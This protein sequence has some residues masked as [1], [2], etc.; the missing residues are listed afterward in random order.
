MLTYSSGYGLGNRSDAPLDRPAAG[1][2]CYTDIKMGQTIDITAYDSTTLLGTTTWIA[3]TSGAQAYAYP[4]DGYRSAEFRPGSRTDT[5]DLTSISTPLR[6]PAPTESSTE[7][8]SISSHLRPG[9]IER[10]LSKAARIGIV[11][12]CVIGALGLIITI[13]F[14]LK[15]VRA[16][17]SRLNFCDPRPAS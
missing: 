1:G 9:D 17:I 10:G 11:L 8:L 7:N 5:Y 14:G 6:H 4:L 3:T 16:F 15:T 12:G 13:V 2:T